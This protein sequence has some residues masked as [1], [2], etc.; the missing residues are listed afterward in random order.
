MRSEVILKSFDAPQDGV[1]RLVFALERTAD[2]VTVTA[3][4]YPD[5]SIGSIEDDDEGDFPLFD[6]TV[7]I[8]EF[9]RLR[10]MFLG[11]MA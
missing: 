9:G 2:H 3:H 5:D 8:E 7:S 11:F 4:M 10:E 1:D 6:G